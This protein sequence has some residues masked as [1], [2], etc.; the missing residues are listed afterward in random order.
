MIVDRIK[1]STQGQMSSIQ[2]AQEL[3]AV[4]SGQARATDQIAMLLRDRLGPEWERIV[5]QVRETGSLAPLAEQFRGLASASGDIQST[6]ESQKSTLSTLLTQVGREGLGGAYEWIVEQLRQANAFLTEH[7][8]MVA[9]DLRAAWENLKPTLQTI[10]DILLAMGTAA[11]KVGSGIAAI[12]G[13]MSRSDEA[14]K[15]IYGLG[16]M[17][18]DIGKMEKAL[19]EARYWEDYEKSETAWRA[20]QIATAAPTRP[21]VGGGEAGAGGGGGGGR[22]ERE[23]VNLIDTLQKEIARLAEGS[24]GE[25][26][27][28]YRH[29][30]GR[31]RAVQGHAEE[32]ARAMELLEKAKTLKLQKVD[33]DYARW[34]AGATGDRLQALELQER[35]VLRK[36]Q[37][38]REQELAIHRHFEDAKAAATLQREG[39]RLGL[40]RQYLSEQQSTT[41]SLAAQLRYRQQMLAIE[42]RLGEMA[43]RQQLLQNRLTRE[44]FQQLDALRRQTEE[45]RRQA[46]L[47]E[48]EE[49]LGGVSGGL[50]RWGRERTEKAETAWSDRAY[51]MME[52]AEQMVSNTISQAII[53]ALKGEQASFEEIG[54]SIAEMFIQKTVELA[55]S[56][57][58]TSLAQVFIQSALG[59][60]APQIAGATAAGAILT[61][62]G[63]KVAAAMVEGAATAAMILGAAKAGTA[64]FFH[65]GGLVMHG[66][67]RIPVAH[68]GLAVDE[69]LIIAQTGEGI[70]PRGSMAKL[71]AGNFEALRRGDFAVGKPGGGGGPVY[72]VSV[73][74]SALDAA[75][76]SSLNWD[77]IAREKIL[78]ALRRGQR[79]Y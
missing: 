39:D 41:T 77:R 68:G 66:G 29:T 19:E 26:D 46:V 13:G 32:A 57:L 51:G 55:V 63:Y 60:V 70:L 27:A 15:Q 8:G 64:G 16:G 2:I 3:R 31:I 20:G 44:E 45:Y 71:G 25:I 53:G 12:I 21:G 7:K 10:L 67:G 74:V 52:G 56:L 62:A 58:F 36:Y 47:R 5:Q 28:W 9:G 33:E 76:V 18:G 38:N 22:G 35:E 54:L 14:M 65:G 37:G 43:L 30:L 79:S 59:T 78:P 11:A 1:L 50:R 42:T 72:N 24:R 17:G 48:R 73:N 4:L 49:R 6:L 69:R 40:A 34:Y 75:G 61:A 23:I